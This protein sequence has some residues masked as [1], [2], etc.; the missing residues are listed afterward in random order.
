MSSSSG[1]EEEILPRP[2]PSGSTDDERNKRRRTEPSDGY[3]SGGGGM[4]A[5]SVELFKDMYTDTKRHNDEIRALRENDFN[6][7]HQK[8]LEEAAAARKKLEEGKV[9]LQHMRQIMVMLLFH[10]FRLRGVI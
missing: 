4:N 1:E 6:A 5:T 10:L 9:E 8:A 2:A 3:E 7:K